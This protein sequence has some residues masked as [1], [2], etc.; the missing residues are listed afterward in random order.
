MTLFM[1]GRQVTED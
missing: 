1:E